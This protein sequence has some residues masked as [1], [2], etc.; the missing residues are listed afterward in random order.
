MNAKMEAGA[1]SIVGPLTSNKNKAKAV[2][3]LNS[4][5]LSTTNNESFTVNSLNVLWEDKLC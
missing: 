2:Y 4:D 1:N 3:L 5:A